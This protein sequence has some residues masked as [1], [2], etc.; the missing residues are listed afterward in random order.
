MV[1]DQHQYLKHNEFGKVEFPKVDPVHKQQLIL[2][3]CYSKCRFD[4]MAFFE[5]MPKSIWV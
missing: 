1:I 4:K 3:V 2:E 5:H